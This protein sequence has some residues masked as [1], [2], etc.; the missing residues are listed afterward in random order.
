M[1]ALFTGWV[2]SNWIR[3]L[4]ILAAVA[5]VMGVLLGARMSGEKIG[6]LEERQRNHDEAMGAIRVRRKIERGVKS[7][8]DDERS[9]WLRYGGPK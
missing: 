3:I 8:P 9:K 7:M 1:I 4:W 6:K 5:T 2:A